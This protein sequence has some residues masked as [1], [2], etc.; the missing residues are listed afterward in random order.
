MAEPRWTTAVFDLDGT[1]IDTIRLI[2][3][4]YQYM[5]EKV[6]GH[7]WEDEDEIKS[8]IGTPLLKT[9][10]RVKPG[11]SEEMLSVYHEF[12]LSRAPEYIRAYDGIPA[13]FA[14][15]RAAGVKYGV[16]TSKLRFSAEL[17]LDI[18][19]LSDVPLLVAADDVT[20][21]KPSPVPLL[22]SIELL[23][24]DP[25]RSVYV[26]D[27]SVDL[28]AAHNAGMAAVGVTWG[29]MSAADLAEEHPTHLVS[30]AAELTVLITG[31]EGEK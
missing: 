24:G 12:N 7:R 20:E 13:M 1:L 15:L 29:A 9:F 18:A 6:L 22:K 21:H 23:A 26:G 11:H 31:A 28:Q 14:A 19:G 4:S 8:W 16:A 3:D 2:V 5:F 17:G 25:A 27:S 10:E 30:T